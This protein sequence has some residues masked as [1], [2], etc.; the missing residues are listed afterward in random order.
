M[1][2]LRRSVPVGLTPGDARGAR[3]E[4]VADGLGVDVAADSSRDGRSTIGDT[5]LP[6]DGSLTPDWYLEAAILRALEPRHILFLCVANSARSQLAE[7]IARSLVATSASGSSGAE[8][9]PGTS[10]PVKISSAGS[11]PTSVRPQ[12]VEVLR[13]VGIDITDQTSNGIDEVEGPVDVVITLCA[14]EVCPVWLDDAWRLHWG[15]PDPA[16]VE[17]TEEERL[18]AFRDVR[19]E[20]HRRLGVLFTGRLP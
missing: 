15:L 20:L 8:A 6:P 13:E 11:E 7:G 12:A 18:A 1:N 5:L 19:D 17:G 9:G 16:G 2:R 4:T 3:I 14:E 10:P